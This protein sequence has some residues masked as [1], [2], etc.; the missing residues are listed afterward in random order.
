M[1]V[2]YIPSPTHEHLESHPYNTRT[3][4][5][6]TSQI[7]EDT[8]CSVFHWV[9]KFVNLRTDEHHLYF[10][11]TGPRERKREIPI[12]RVFSLR[13]VNLKIR[14]LLCKIESRK[15][16]RGISFSWKIRFVLS[17]RRVEFCSKEHE[18]EKEQEEF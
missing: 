9:S 13:Y 7:S 2:L 8:S 16:S 4:W 17:Q 1:P 10:P 12:S 6:L 5:I 11:R 18:S 3:V 14:L 15:R